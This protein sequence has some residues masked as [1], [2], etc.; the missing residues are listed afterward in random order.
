MPVTS[1]DLRGSVCPD[2]NKLLDF[3]Q[4]RLPTSEVDAIDLHADRCVACRKAIDE[5]VCAFR[6]RSTRL[7]LV[8][9]GTVT[10]FVGGDVLDGRY[11]IIRF[12]ARGGMGEVYEAEDQILGARVAVKTVAATISDNPLAARRLKREVMVARRIT[13]PNVCRIFDLGVHRGTGE[14]AGSEVLFITMEL[15]EG[16]S[17]AQALAKDGPFA[18]AVAQPIARAMATAI[19]A[20]HRAGVVHRDF[21]TDNVMLAPGDDLTPRVVVMDFGL[22]RNASPSTQDSLEGR[23]LAG[24]L[25]YMSPEQLDGQRPGRASDIYALGVVMHEM[26]TG[27]LPFAPPQGEPGLSTVLMRLSDPAPLLR[28]LLPGI[29]DRWNDLVARCLERD[30]ERRAF[31]DEVVRALADEGAPASATSASGQSARRS[32]GSPTAVP[33]ERAWLRGTLVAAILAGLAA[34]VMT[35]VVRHRTEARGTVSAPSSLSPAPTPAAAPPPSPEPSPPPSPTA[36]AAPVEANGPGP[37]GPERA[38]PATGAGEPAQA[39]S[40]APRPAA[41]RRPARAG[42]AASPGTGKRPVDGVGAAAGASSRSADPDEGF[43]FQ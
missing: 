29:D 26:L 2:E 20:A 30:A 7:E 32:T 27:R 4:G 3:V 39:S 5:A 35:L 6:E 8:S 16:R 41:S 18:P 9:M 31:A 13:H 15:I 42:S 43:I 12:I 14:Q 1:E 38:S 40:R 25:A 34:A 10:R 22:A 37:A 24:T 23:G 19:D 33:R 28:S 17:L 36:A 11:R 21:K